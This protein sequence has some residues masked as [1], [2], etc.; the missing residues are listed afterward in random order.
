[1]H[2]VG[3]PHGDVRGACRTPQ[4]QWRVSTLP[5]RRSSGPASFSLPLAATVYGPHEM[6]SLDA[7][8][9]KASLLRRE[10][11]N[12]T[13]DGLAT[14]TVEASNG[15]DGSDDDLQ[16]SSGVDVHGQQSGWDRRLHGSGSDEED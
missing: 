8:M 3:S 12:L 2:G 4:P 16:F 13:D 10:C 14:A 1:V 9:R 15:S 5:R 11:S 6:L 7:A